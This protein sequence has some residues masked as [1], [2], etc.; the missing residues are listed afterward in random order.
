LNTWSNKRKMTIETN[1]FRLRVED[2]IV[3]YQKQIHNSIFYSK[4]EYAWNGAKIEFQL[5][6]KFSGVYDINRRAIYAEDILEFKD[7]KNCN[8]GLVLF[9]EVL[10]EFQIMDLSTEELVIDSF[11]DISNLPTFVFKSY[12]FI[13]P[14]V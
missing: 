11:K 4:D 14:E 10:S 13:Q 8:F 12:S 3:G 9:D 6:D 1:R 5:K 7:W 2:K